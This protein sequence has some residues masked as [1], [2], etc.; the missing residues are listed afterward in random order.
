M[1]D[2][3]TSAELLAAVGDLTTD[4]DGPT[5]LPFEAAFPADEADEGVEA[6]VP[7][8]NTTSEHE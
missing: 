7:P 8:G 3:G 1:A 2:A 6:V 5:D 4:D